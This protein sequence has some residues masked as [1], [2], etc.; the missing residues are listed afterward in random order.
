VSL[1]CAIWAKL[2]LRALLLFPAIEL[3][4]LRGLLLKAQSLT[5]LFPVILPEVMALTT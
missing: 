4:Q 2:A 1:R 5:N 3:T